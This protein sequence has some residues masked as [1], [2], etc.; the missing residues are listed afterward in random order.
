MAC[1][2]TCP[3]RNHITLGECLRAKNVRIGWEGQDATAEK[4]G[5]RD[6]EAYAAARR[7]GVQP[8]STRRTDTDRAMR[9]SD[10]HGTAYR[11]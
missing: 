10:E 6:L 5:K 3:T 1:S 4:R 11:P 8:D 2:S 7:Q 9:W